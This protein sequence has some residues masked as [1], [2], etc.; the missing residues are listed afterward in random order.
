VLEE[1]SFVLLLG[2]KSTKLEVLKLNLTT[3]EEGG[4]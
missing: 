1:L 4:G 2:I 3:N